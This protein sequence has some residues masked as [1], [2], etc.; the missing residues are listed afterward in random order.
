MMKNILYGGA[1]K[2]NDLEKYCAYQKCQKNVLYNNLK[3]STNDTSMSCRMRQAQY[4][5]SASTVGKCNKLLDPEG[6][7]VT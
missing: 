5:K 6:N 2:S 1:S 7:I 3:T 4:I